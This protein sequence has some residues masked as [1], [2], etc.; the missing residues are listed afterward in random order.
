MDTP[1]RTA[2]L[3]PY[4]QLSRHHGALASADPATHVIVMVE[5]RSMLHSRT[6]HAQ[7]LHLVLSAA[8][9]VAADLRAEGF[10]VHSL[11]AESVAEGIERFR[12]AQL[13]VRLIASQP[14]SR[15]L[16][17]VL[18]RQGVE[19]VD[20]DHFITTRTQFTEWAET[21]RTMVMED[22]YRWQRRRLDLMMT[23]GQP[24][25]GQWN[26]DADNRLPPPKGAYAWPAPLHFD[27]DDI[28]IETWDR[29]QGMGLSLAGEPP[30][31]TWATTRG[32]ALRQLE[33]F[34][35]TSLAGFGP[36]EDA[37]PSGTWSAHHSLLSTYLNLGLL[38]PTEVVAAAVERFEQGG[39]PL[40]SLEGFVRQVVGWRE[41]VN[42][43]YWA[44]DDAYRDRNGLD[45]QRPL[46]PALATGQTSMA[47]VQGIVGD[48]LKRGWV[49]HIPRLMV[50]AN[51]A[52]I[53]GIRP[54]AM[55]DWM[56]RMFVDAADW[57]MVPNVIGMGVHADGGQMMTK[58][59]AAGGAYISRMGQYCKACPFDPRK[60]TGNDACPFTTLYWDFLDRNREQ[61][62]RNHR[63]GQQVRGLDRLS[64]SLIHI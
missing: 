42:G 52:L 57:V 17:Q 59:Y 55:L 60:R 36:Y 53:T 43:V 58:P 16:Q 37:M 61:F 64:L 25:G 19:L 40:A 11:Q 41:Y 33:H 23:D 18:L 38:S 27:L 3:L 54:S 47:C 50:L 8:A 46:P 9:H 30:S 35:Q 48:V 34:L 7:R 31:G 29:M 13:G 24:W 44:F 56:R 21:K 5:S 4:D 39:V 14:T 32:G 12:A 63:M 2:V 51:L 26:F 20:D 62:A 45:A 1:S 6:W 22:F 15:R 10:V 49:H 28:D